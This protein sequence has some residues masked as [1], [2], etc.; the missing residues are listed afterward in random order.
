MSN[1][2]ATDNEGT[3]NQGHPLGD[4]LLGFEMASYSSHKHHKIFIKLFLLQ[5]V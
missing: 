3:V 2:K 4:V 1:V 5:D